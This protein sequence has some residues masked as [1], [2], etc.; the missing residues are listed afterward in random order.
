MR[1]VLVGARGFIGG[2]VRR[3]L[4]RLHPDIRPVCITRGQ[5]PPGDDA[6]WISMD[7]SRVSV[8]T[9]RRALDRA[10]P[11]VVV[12]C[13]GFTG[14]SRRGLVDA[15]ARVVL[16]LL[17]A[18]SDMRR[19]PRV[20]QIGSGAEYGEGAPGRAS[21]ETDEP[22]P[23]GPY[24]ATKLIATQLVTS[25]A[26]SGLDALVLRV[27]NPIGPGAPEQSLAGAAARKI[28]TAL[29]LGLDHVE[30]GPLDAFRDFVDIRDVAR[31]VGIACATE[32]LAGAVLNVG[33]GTAVTARM[34]VGTLV[35]AS[36]YRGRITER[37]AGSDRSQRVSW[38]EADVTLVRRL[39]GWRAEI[40]LER[41]TADLWASLTAN[42]HATAMSSRTA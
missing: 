25:A 16:N 6:R 26:E 3:E 35:A 12:N 10:A 13:A 28:R 18:A 34:V 5:P 29:E 37:G 20:V 4:A 24:G 30:L 42:P 22:H 15:N 36:A 40:P 39:L 38:Q 23:A 7:L 9:V 2:A 19:P 14:R 17:V 33:S 11:D 1:V 41:S 32:G 8:T 21:R 31:A 27:F